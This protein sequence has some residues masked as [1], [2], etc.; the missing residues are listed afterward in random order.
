MNTVK[1]IVV[2]ISLAITTSLAAQVS[3]TN[4]TPFVAEVRLSYELHYNLEYYDAFSSINEQEEGFLEYGVTT[5]Y[6]D[7]FSTYEEEYSI[8]HYYE[9]YGYGT[10]Y[11]EMLIEVYNYSFGVGYDPYHPNSLSTGSFPASFEYEHS[12]SVGYKYGYDVALNGGQY[13]KISL[14][15]EGSLPMTMMG[16][17]YFTNEGTKMDSHSQEYIDGFIQGYNYIKYTLPWLESRGYL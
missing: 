14:V 1:Y 5:I 17:I 16:L 6:V 13:P 7:P 4:N 15:E 8:T 11:R 2:A 12:Y 10:Y 9:Q 3:F